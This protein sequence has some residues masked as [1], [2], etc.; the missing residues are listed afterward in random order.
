MYLERVEATHP[1]HGNV[2]IM[3]DRLYTVAGRSMFTD[4]GIRFL[5]LDALDRAARSK[6]TS[7]MTKCRAPMNSYKC[8]TRSS[9]C[10]W[11]FPICSPPTER[12]SSCA[13]SRSILE[14]NRLNLM[15]DGKAS[16]VVRRALTYGP[17]MKTIHA[18]L[19]GDD[20]EGRG[21]A[22]VQWQ[23]GFLDDSWW[24]R[25]YWV[26]GNYHASGH[27]G[28]TQAGSQGNPAGRM[29]TFDDDRI[30]TWGRLKLVLPVV[31]G[32]SCITCTPRTTTTRT[33]GMHRLADSGACNGRLG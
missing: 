24:H 10:P 12:R 4:G 28:Y 18:K 9:I 1:V 5:I 11:R 29:I 22:L 14:G 3:N 33:S 8:G 21:R 32:I 25:T 31:G 16:T 13:I 27:S 7:W 23:Q 2:L 30:Y 19:G 6:N 17:D 20:A 26:Y 15:F